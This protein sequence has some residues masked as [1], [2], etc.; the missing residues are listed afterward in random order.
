[1]TYWNACA[2]I[3]FDIWTLLCVLVHKMLYYSYWRLPLPWCTAGKSSWRSG[4]DLGLLYDN[5]TPNPTGSLSGP[6]FVESPGKTVIGV[7]GKTSNLACSVKNLGNMTVGIFIRYKFE[8][9]TLENANGRYPG[10]DTK[11]PT[12]WPLECFATLLM[13]GSPVCTSPARRIGSLS[14]EIPRM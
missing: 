4:S 13:T 10:S 14:W 2:G 1:M 11:T 8:S 12:C 6:Y 3:T 7:K 5:V 9:I